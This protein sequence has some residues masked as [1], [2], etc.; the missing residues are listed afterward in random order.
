MDTYIYICTYRELQYLFS[1]VVAVVLNEGRYDLEAEYSRGYFNSTST[2]S[3]N[4]STGTTSSNATSSSSGRG[5]SAATGAASSEGINSDAILQQTD[6]YGASLARPMDIV[7]ECVAT[8]AGGM[9]ELAPFLCRFIFVQCKQHSRDYGVMYA[10]L[11]LTNALMEN[12]TI[13]ITPWLHQVYIYI[14]IC[15]VT[16]IWWSY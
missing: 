12:S 6:G 13:T 7:C 10:L 1:R 2:T 11:R 16:Y 3:T 8:D 5:T 14:Y 4:T 15:D 9:R